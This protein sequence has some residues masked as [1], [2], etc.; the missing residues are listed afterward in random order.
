MSRNVIAA[1]SGIA[2]LAPDTA[3]L[4]LWLRA[5][6]ADYNTAAEALKKGAAIVE[7]A[8]KTT[9]VD[10][11]VKAEDFSVDARYEYKKDL[12]GNQKRVLA[13]YEAR[14]MVRVTVA[15]EGVN[16]ILVQNALQ[17]CGADAD[18]T[19]SYS[20][21]DESAAEKLA[22][23]K[24]CKDAREKAEVMC[25]AAGVKLGQL[26]SVS[27]GS[28]AVLQPAAPVMLRA[29][30]AEAAPAAVEAEDIEVHAT[31]TLVFEIE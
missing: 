25:A 22:L 15:H 29:V 10:V 4:A 5:Q 14:Q 21:K 28:E 13:G 1:G 9:G 26:I 30:A 18:L 20:L 27:N 16:V 24:A 31:A 7:A 17:K 6:N 23:E 8:V 11:Q 3:T 2:R 19:V 12:A